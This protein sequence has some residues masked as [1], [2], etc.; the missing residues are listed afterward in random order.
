M[1]DSKMELRNISPI[2]C[3]SIPK[4]YLACISAYILVYVD[5]NSQRKHL[6]HNSVCRQKLS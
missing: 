4:N 3:T 5:R 2:L 6:I 1:R